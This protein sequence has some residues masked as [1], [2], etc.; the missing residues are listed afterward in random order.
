MVASKQASVESSFVIGISR[1]SFSFFFF[2]TLIDISGPP[3]PQCELPPDVG[4]LRRGR[5]GYMDGHHL[6]VTE[7]Y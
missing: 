1:G 5:F 6:E 2:I 3:V 7:C 4:V